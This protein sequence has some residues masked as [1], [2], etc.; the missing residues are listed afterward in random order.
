MTKSIGFN[1][2]EIMEIKGDT[3][4]W[5]GRKCKNKLLNVSSALKHILKSVE[6]KKEYSSEE[7]Q[8]I[9]SLSR[10]RTEQKALERQRLKYDADTR[11][12]KHKQSY[13]SS[14]GLVHRYVCTSNPASSDL[15]S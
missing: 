12:E 2:R 13:N 9:R 7:I 6:C 11:S 1:F 5:K 8:T 3:F 14:C 4:S 10:K 15:V